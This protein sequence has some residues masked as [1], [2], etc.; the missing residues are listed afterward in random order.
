MTRSKKAITRFP[1]AALVAAGTLLVAPAMAHAGLV[2]NA[3]TFSTQVGT[4]LARSTLATFS[5]DNPGTCSASGYTSVIDWGDGTAPETATTAFRFGGDFTL[6]E[7]TISADHQYAKFGVYN[8]AITVTGTNG[9]TGADTGEIT[10]SDVDIAGAFQPFSANAGSVFNGVVASFKDSNPSSQPGNFTST[11]DWGDGTPVISGT[12]GGAN[13]N[14]T[15][16]GTHTYAAPGS[17]TVRSTLEHPAGPPSV[18]V[19]TV[20]VGGAPAGGGGGAN[21]NPAALPTVQMRLLGSTL[22]R[23]ALR[24]KGLAVRVTVGNSKSRTLKVTILRNGKSFATSSLKLQRTDGRAQ[25]VRWKP[26]AKLL[27]RLRSGVTYGF[28]VAVGKQASA[29]RAFRLRAT[30]R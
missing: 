30:P 1:V 26:S 8:T 27:K 10:V 25:T 21:P 4:K 19:G 28:R 7:Y 6:C 2:V 17:Y 24:T 18:A 15:V 12:V 14:L 16:S 20:T 5:D 13:G 11:I 3:K 23:R 22:S 9:H 29:T